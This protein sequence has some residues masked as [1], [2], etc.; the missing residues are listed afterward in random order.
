MAL[1]PL[2]EEFPNWVTKEML[3][4]DAELLPYVNRSSALAAIDYIVSLSSDVFLP[5]HGGNM[6][7]AMQVKPSSSSVYG[8]ICLVSFEYGKCGH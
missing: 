8:S 4:R 1:K 6:G 2:V 5:S 7:R 3:A